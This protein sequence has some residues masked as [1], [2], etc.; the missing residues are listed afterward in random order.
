MPAI[1][2]RRIKPHPSAAQLLAARA[3]RAQAEARRAFARAIGLTDAAGRAR[4]L[5]TCTDDRLT[6]RAIERMQRTSR[7]HTVSALRAAG[8][9]VS[10]G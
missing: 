6:L 2:L 4:P 9:L 7:K 3:E 1:I 8:I 5:P 10:R